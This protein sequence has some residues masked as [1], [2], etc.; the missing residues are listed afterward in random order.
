L[1]RGA[2]AQGHLDERPG[3][4]V[5]PGTARRGHSRK[6]AARGGLPWLIDGLLTLL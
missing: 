4:R 1:R 3:A 2:A 5:E 6:L